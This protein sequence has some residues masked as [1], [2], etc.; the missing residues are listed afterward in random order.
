MKPRQYRRVKIGNPY[1]SGGGGGRT[2]G[3][4]VGEYEKEGVGEGFERQGV[5][6]MEVEQT[7]SELEVDMGEGE[8][9]RRK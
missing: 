5:E 3:R 4:Q 6:G 8:W 9:G 7:W 2:A 1:G